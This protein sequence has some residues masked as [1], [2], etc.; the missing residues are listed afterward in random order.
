[1]FGEAGFRPGSRATFVS[2][3]VAK[4]ML[5]VA[6]PPASD[7]VGR[8]VAPCLRR[9]KLFGSPARFANSFGLAQD[10]PGGAQTRGAGPEICRRTQPRPTGLFKRP[11]VGRMPGVSHGNE[12]DAWRMSNVELKS[13]KCNR[14]R[15]S[16]ISAIQ[17]KNRW[18]VYC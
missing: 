1:M 8:G 11:P 7:H 3:K 5:A 2:A 12:D 13:P 18:A 9:G 4:T 14:I 15:Y 10:R 17:S 6:W 16:D